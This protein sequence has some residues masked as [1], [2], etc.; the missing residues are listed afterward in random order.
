M[1]ELIASIPM[2]SA[3]ICLPVNFFKHFLTGTV[4]LKFQMGDA[5]TKLCSNGSGHTIKIATTHIYGNT[6]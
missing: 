5:G 6:R 4:K 2:T 3:S 1:G